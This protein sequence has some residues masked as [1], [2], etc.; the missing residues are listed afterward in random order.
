MKYIHVIYIFLIIITS[1]TLTF[2]AGIPT[3]IIL[4]ENGK[5]ITT[6]GRGAVSSDPEGK[7]GCDL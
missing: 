6:N 2:L 3:L 4:D 5:V 7:V 1:N